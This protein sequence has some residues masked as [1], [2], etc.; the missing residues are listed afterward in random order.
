MKN[1]HYRVCDN[2]Y[3]LPVEEEEEVIHP[4]PLK[5]DRSDP[6]VLRPKP[7][8]R[9]NPMCMF[10]RHHRLSHAN[11]RLSNLVVP[12]VLST[13]SYRLESRRASYLTLPLRLHLLL[14]LIKS[15]KSKR[16]SYLNKL[17]KIRLIRPLYAVHQ[18][19]LLVDRLVQNRYRDQWHLHRLGHRTL[20]DWNRHFVRSQSYRRSLVR[21]STSYYRIICCER[22]LRGY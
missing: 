19:I 16:S 22:R 7:S 5:N 8:R 6:S 12:P 17:S 20:S 3:L 2:F 10:D 9:R 1:P 14:R 4:S 18:Y 13:V 11:R 21:I 15:L